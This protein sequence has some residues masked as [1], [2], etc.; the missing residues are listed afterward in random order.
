M[1]KPKKSGLGKGLEALFADN[2]TTEPAINTLHIDEIEPNRS[3]P[4]SNF[5][6]QQLLELTESIRQHGVLQ[7]LVVRPMANG[8]YQIVAG[9]RRWRASRNAGITQLPVVVKELSDREAMELALVENLL[10]EDLTPMEEALGYRQLMEVYGMTQEVVAQRVG[11]S[12]PAITN[13]LRLLNLPEEVT[14][15]LN[16]GKLSAG[17]ARALV[18]LEKQRAI[19][20]A[21]L[22]VDKG[23]SVR[24]AEELAKQKPQAV[25]TKILKAGEG[26]SYYK[27][28][29]LSLNEYLGRKVKV[30][31]D[32]KGKGRLT[33]SFHSRD[34]LEEFVRL[35][36]PNEENQ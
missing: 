35:L 4:R 16:G 18:P 34:E 9:E 31:A 3:Q 27:E 8:R 5:D 1:A 21:K 2:T 14:Q 33:L 22:I 6:P 11:R 10:R 23:L 17:H 28:I 30:V 25:P 15:L 29:E 26:Q 24:Q 7:P 20:I 13:A 32:S 19:D 36:A 12:R